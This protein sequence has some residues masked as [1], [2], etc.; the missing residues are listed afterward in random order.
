MRATLALVT[1]TL[2]ALPAH[3]DA[4]PYTGPYKIENCPTIMAAFANPP[5]LLLT[6]LRAQPRQADDFVRNYSRC[7]QQVESR[8]LRRLGSVLSV[9]K[10][11]PFNCDVVARVGNWLHQNDVRLTGPV[12]PFHRMSVL[13]MQAGNAAD[14]ANNANDCIRLEP[15]PK[16][17]KQ[18]AAKRLKWP[19]FLSRGSRDGVLT[20]HHRT[21]HERS[22]RRQIMRRAGR[23]GATA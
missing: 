13:D 9:S 2:L 19:K 16:P 20:K 1:L 21:L 7:T 15:R 5:S 4:S 18:A 17:P 14:L 11:T 6:Q 8:V 3:G 10:A 22:M 23:V 12:W